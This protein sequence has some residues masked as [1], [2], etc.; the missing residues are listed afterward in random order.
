[1]NLHP[2]TDA[3]SFRVGHLGSDSTYGVVP[4]RVTPKQVRTRDGWRYDRATGRCLNRG[5]RVRVL[6]A[7]RI[8]PLG[9]W[10]NTKAGEQ[11]PRP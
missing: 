5:R 9:A 3:A 7:Y 6:L 2:M 1:M 8:G 11:E 4:A 10:T